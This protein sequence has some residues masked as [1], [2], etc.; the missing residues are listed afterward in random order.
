MNF[1]VRVENFYVCGRNS[2][3]T[4]L[5]RAPFSGEEL[6]EWWQDV[7]F[8]LTGDGHPCGSR[9][10]ALYEV[11]IIDSPGSPELLGEKYGWG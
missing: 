10:D 2:T 5:V 7:V 9:E 1:T 3:S 6:E 11:T 4:D 8:D